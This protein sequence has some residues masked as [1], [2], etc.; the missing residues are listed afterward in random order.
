M[1]FNSLLVDI[2][3]DGKSEEYF[4]PHNVSNEELMQLG[5]EWILESDEPK[6]KS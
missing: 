2:L 6:F 1:C 3:K 5:R 4:W